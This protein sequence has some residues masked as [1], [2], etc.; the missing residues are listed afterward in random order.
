MAPSSANTLATAIS[1]P[2]TPGA[3]SSSTP[4]TSIPISTTIVRA[5]KPTSPSTRK[6][7]AAASTAT[8]KLPWRP[9]WPCPTRRSTCA[10]DSPLPCYN[11]SREPAAT[12]E[13]PSV[14][15]TP[16]ADSLRS[17]DPL[18]QGRGND[19]RGKSPK[20]KNG[21]FSLPWK[22]HTPKAR[23]P[24]IIK[25]RPFEVGFECDAKLYRKEHPY[26]H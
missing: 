3:C 18:R 8:I 7:A 15:N 2:G 12:P 11:A 25:G 19:G 9:C 10:P 16:N 24:R 22:A 20:D 14:C 6:A 13:P 5:P 26:G 23:F 17:C 4:P 1:R 21:D